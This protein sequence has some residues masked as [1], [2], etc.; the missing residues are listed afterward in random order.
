MSFLGEAYP[1]RSEMFFFTTVI[2]NGG[3]PIISKNNIHYAD[4]GIE[5]KQ[6]NPYI[7]DNNITECS[8]NLIAPV[9]TIER[10]YFDGIIQI[11]NAVVKSNTVT[12][13][14]V[15]ESFSPTISNNNIGSIRL[16]SS[17]NVD[18]A[19]NWW[20]TT[21]TTDIERAIW[22]YNDDFT[23]GKVNY[24]PFLTEPN[25]KAIPDPNAEIPTVN[26]QNTNQTLLIV[27]AVLSAVIA[28]SVI[29]L[30][31]RSKLSGKH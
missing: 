17:T 30:L 16:S 21:N 12:Y 24:T 18:A 23:L 27:S 10:N 19:N 15:Q 2:V 13:I 26:S 3:S 6:G 28:G 22:D 5:I 11:G 25:P 8:P 9:G 31:L 29:I 4:V 1:R 14:E 7:S 20:G